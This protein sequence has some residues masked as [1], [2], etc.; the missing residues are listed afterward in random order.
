MSL[1]FANTEWDYSE[2]TGSIWVHA[3]E[4]VKPAGQVFIDYDQ[5]SNDYMLLNYGFAIDENFFNSIEIDILELNDAFYNFFSVDK[6]FFMTK[7]NLWQYDAAV[8]HLREY[9]HSKFKIFF[10]RIP[11]KIDDFFTHLF[12]ESFNLLHSYTAIKC[13]SEN[14]KIEDFQNCEILQDKIKAEMVRY[15]LEKRLIELNNCTDEFNKSKKTLDD[16]KIYQIS[17]VFKSH[18]VIC[19]KWHEELSKNIARLDSDLKA[20][21]EKIKSENGKPFNEMSTGIQA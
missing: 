10:D 4:D 6:K 14:F 7:F 11:F 20:F 16:T 2:T 1:D 5:G 13:F 12:T 17:A 3:I 15:C 18:E 19:E 9:S 8:S 21:I